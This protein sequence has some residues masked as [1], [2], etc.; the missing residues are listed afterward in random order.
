MELILKSNQNS[1]YSDEINN[2]YIKIDSI[3]LKTTLKLNLF[4]IITEFYWKILSQ[5]EVI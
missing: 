2:R 4:L 3:S 5:I 1:K